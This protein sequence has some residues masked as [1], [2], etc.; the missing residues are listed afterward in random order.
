MT[1][2]SN[3]YQALYRLDLFLRRQPGPLILSYHSLSASGWKYA[4]PLACF[5]AHIR[6]LLSTGWKPVSLG[7]INRYYSQ[8]VSLPRLCFAVTFDDGF[9][10][11]LQAEKFL[12]RYRIRPALFVIADPTRLEPGQISSS[13]P[14]LNWGQIRSLARSGW[15]IGCHSLTH[16][17]FSRLTTPQLSRQTRTAKKLLEKQLGRTVPYFAYPKGRFS[18]AAVVA[19]KASGFSL[20]L[21]VQPDYFKSSSHPWLLPRLGLENWVTPDLFLPFISPAAVGL[22]RLKSR[23]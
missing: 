7:E 21:T 13:E 11:V 19:V 18:P 1:V 8:K 3:I 15:E 16:P 2:K 6:L 9:T 5:Q 17:D 10:S 12:H 14:R 20:G 22:R 23:L 4:V